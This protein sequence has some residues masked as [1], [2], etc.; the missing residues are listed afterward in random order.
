MRLVPSQI[1]LNATAAAAAESSDIPMP[2]MRIS[3]TEGSMDSP[4]DAESSHFEYAPI[5]KQ[6]AT[7][8][9]CR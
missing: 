3:R 4:P 5:V 7:L 1:C 8:S 9:T 6:T 2:L